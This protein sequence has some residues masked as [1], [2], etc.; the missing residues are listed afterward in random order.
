MSHAL[1]NED[2]CLH[3]Y[4]SGKYNDWV[5]TTSF[6]SALHF[7]NEHFPCQIDG[8]EHKNFHKY[9]TKLDH[10]Y[11]KH[12][13]RVKLAGYLFGPEA[14]ISYR[15]LRDMSSTARYEDYN[16]TYTK[17][18][19]AIEELQNFKKEAEV[20]DKNKCDEILAELKEK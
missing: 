18:Q 17:A 6:Y 14:E 3:L 2:A 12:E 16:I 5:L 1:H 9:Y 8:Y 19:M 11:S 7:I 13:A 4:R 20:V 10:N 15:R